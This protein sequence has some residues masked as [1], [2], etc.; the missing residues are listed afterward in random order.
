MKIK[1]L[2]KIYPF[3]LPI[4]ECETIDLFLGTTLKDEVL[5][6]M[7]AQMQT[8]ANQKARFKASITNGEYNDHFGLDVECSKEVATAV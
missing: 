6:T 3:S 2:E 4:K 5:K 1:S 7:P 8:W